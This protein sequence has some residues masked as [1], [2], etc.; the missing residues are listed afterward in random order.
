V[1][2]PISCSAPNSGK[3]GRPTRSDSHTLPSNK[4]SEPRDGVHM[5][6]TSEPKNKQKMTECG[7]KRT[8]AYEEQLLFMHCGF[9][10]S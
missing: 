7:S 8:R 3:S 6:M 4:S 10:L 2:R 9:I 5:E 1:D